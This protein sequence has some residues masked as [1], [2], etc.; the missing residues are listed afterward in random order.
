MSY[1]V[2]HLGFFDL[3][4]GRLDDARAKLE[5]SVAVRREIGFAP[6]VAAGVLALAELE[7]ASGRLAEALARLDEAEQ[8]A[9]ACGALGILGR[10]HEARAELTRPDPGPN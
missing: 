9:R 3:H 1:A 8:L 6:G 2:R 10:I 7:G 5:E 4:A